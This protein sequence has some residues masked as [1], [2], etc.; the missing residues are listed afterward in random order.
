M[1]NIINLDEEKEF[2]KGEKEFEL[3]YGYNEELKQEV[4]QNINALNDEQLKVLNTIA[5]QIQK[6][7]TF[8]VIGEDY[9]PKDRRRFVKMYINEVNQLLMKAKSINDM[10]IL[11]F[12]MQKMNYDTGEIIVPNA[13]ISDELKMDK[14]LVS[15]GLKNLINDEVI[16]IK[17]G[18][19]NK[20][21]KI[22]LLNEKYFK[23][24]R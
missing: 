18:Y 16:L 7:N 15:K 11:L 3:L 13:M 5:I 14:S 21:F 10:K 1:D 17:E 19:E 8:T 2:K 12:L 23:Y 20:K 6:D 22:Y 4:T 24:G 9:K